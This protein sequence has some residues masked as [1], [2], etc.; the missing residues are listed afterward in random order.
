MTLPPTAP[1]PRP[2]P[3][4]SVYGN[5]AVLL[6]GKG[7]NALLSLATLALAA[8]ALGVAQFGLLVLVHSFA[9][10]V[11][12]IAKFQTWQLL[13]QYGQTALERGERQRFLPVLR[14]ALILDLL[15][16][17]LGLLLALA[18]L[19]L[20]WPWLNWPP[21][22]RLPAA[23]YMSSILFLVPGTPLGLLR[24]LDRFDLLALRSGVGALLRLL[25]AGLGWWLGLGL[26]GFLAIWYLSGLLSLA[27][28]ASAAAGQL[29]QRGL[30]SGPWP[31]SSGLA[32]AIPGIWRFVWQ[33]NLN[34]SLG[35]ASS[36][37]YTLMV[38]SLIGSAGAALFHVAR[39]LAE[40]ISKAGDLLVAA[41]YPQ[42]VRLR[43]QSDLAA[44]RGLAWRLS[45]ACGAV[46]SG[47]LLLFAPLA[48]ELLG[49]VLGE[50]PAQGARFAVLLC[51]AAVI[52]LWALPLE[53]LLISTG[54]IGLA[55]SARALVL[56]LQIPSCYLLCIEWG[57]DGAAATAILVALAS[58]TLQALPL[59]GRAAPAS[60]LDLRA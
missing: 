2:D 8:R 1:S 20:A 56:L 52:R 50:A 45:L 11:A 59:L 3:L 25:G 37:L 44:M 29:R 55:S 4:R 48:G 28:S 9:S 36:H 53:P 39:Q 13:L 17:L 35:V 46:A 18:V 30:L 54:R 42:L 6:G 47:L 12:D 24:A 40:G 51:A 21:E 43:E 27:L 7:F 15:S 22:L 26:G 33:N 5:A 32:P 34:L 60:N 23:L 57:L 38:G 19:A 10:A 49:W 31:A 41:L 58:L 14:F 16:G